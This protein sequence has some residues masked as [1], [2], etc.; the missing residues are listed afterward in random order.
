M[1]LFRLE[2][3]LLSEMNDLYSAEKQLVLAL[4]RM[5]RA[6]HC[7]MLADAFEAHLVHTDTHL[8]R[9]ERAFSILG[10]G[11]TLKICDPIKSLIETADELIVG[12]ADSLIRD[13]GLLAISHKIEHYEIAGYESARAMARLVGNDR[14]ARLLEATLEEELFAA[15]SL[16]GLSK[17]MLIPLASG[18]TA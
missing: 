1:N 14:V 17:N 7:V 18:A 13:V 16:E 3:L 15:D 6:T 4:P 11:P 10:E 8:E 12:A 5:A 9:L 2:D